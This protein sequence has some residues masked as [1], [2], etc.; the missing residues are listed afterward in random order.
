[1]DD[2]DTNVLGHYLKIWGDN[3]ACT[4]EV[5]GGT[6]QLTYKTFIVTSNY[7]ISQLWKDDP[8]MAAAIARRFKTYTITGD[9][10]SGYELKNLDHYCSY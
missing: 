1:M 7:K 9:Y 2:L 3:Y 10:Q 8:V 6:V 5:K 4:G